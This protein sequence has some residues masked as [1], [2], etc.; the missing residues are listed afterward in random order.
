LCPEPDT[1]TTSVLV[2]MDQTI[3]QSDPIFKGVIQSFR[4]GTVTRQQSDVIMKRRLIQLPPEEYTDF[5]DNALYVMPTWACTIPVTIAYLKKNGKPVA[6]SD[7]KYSFQAGHRNHAVK[8]SSLPKRTSLVEDIVVMLLMNDIVELG[9]KNS[10]I[11]TIKAVMYKDAEGPHGPDGFKTHPA[12]AVV[13]FPDCKIPEEDKIMPGWPSTYVP[14]VQCHDRCE[15]KCCAVIKIPMRPCNAIAI[16]KSQGQLVGPNEVWKK[17]VV[18]FLAAQ[19]R[20]KTPG[21]EQVAF[22]RA[23][24]LNCLAVLD[25]SENTHDMSMGIG[26]GKSSKNGY[27]TWLPRHNHPSWTR[28]Q[29]MT[30][31]PRRHLMVVTRLCCSGIITGC[32][33]TNHD[34][35]IIFNYTSFICHLLLHLLSIYTTLSRFLHHPKSFPFKLHH[36]VVKESEL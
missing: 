25:E 34:K 36:V 21:L 33:P 13:D 29:R 15:H 24:S 32:H 20:N 18:E 35:L 12:Y 9:L 31:P 28:L 3:R 16:H 19:A 26:K 23:T 11:G 10:S 27:E 4:D 2:I 30:L 8:D 7:I 5:C 14:I 22:S 6:R 1:G 17:I